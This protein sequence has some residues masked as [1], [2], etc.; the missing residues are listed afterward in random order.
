MMLEYFPEPDDEIPF[1]ECEGCH[2]DIYVGDSYWK[3]NGALLHADNACLYEYYSD[4]IE[5]K[6]ATKR[7]V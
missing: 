5:A 4:E 3:L 2:E 6:I 1:A 7:R